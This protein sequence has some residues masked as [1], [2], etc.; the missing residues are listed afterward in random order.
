MKI[1]VF[2]LTTDKLKHTY[3][4]PKDQTVNN[5]AQYVNPIVEIGETCENTYLY[6]ADVIQHGL[7]VYSLLENRSWRINNTKSNI[8]G[9]DTEAVTLN[10]AGET[11]ELNDG[12]LGM[13][14]SPPN[15]FS[16]R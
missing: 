16:K 4:I 6:V 2:D 11:I 5:T 13:S 10:I 8:F 15:F 7:L 3:I 12:I 14:L 9:H 1:M